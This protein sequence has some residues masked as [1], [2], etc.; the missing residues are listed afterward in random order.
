VT[1]TLRAL[2]ATGQTR[3]QDTR[4]GGR[5]R[6]PTW[7]LAGVA[8]VLFA[9]ATFLPLLASLMQ[10]AVDSGEAEVRAVADSRAAV[11]VATDQVQVLLQDI[12]VVAASV[13]GDPNFWD[14]DDAARDAILARLAA[15]RPTFNAVSFFTE[16][17]RQHGSSS[18]SPGEPRA[19][20]TGRAYAREAVAT[21]QT[22]FA[23]EALLS[24][25]TKVPVL[26][27]AVPVRDEGRPGATGREGLIVVALRLERLPAVWADLALP[28]GSAMA[29][30]DAR[31]GRV[32]AG[33][34]PAAG[35]TNELLARGDL[36]RVGRGEREFRTAAPDLDPRG[37][38]RLRAWSVVVDTPWAVVVD[39]PDAAVLAP[40]A[41][42]ARFRAVFAL[43]LAGAVLVPLLFLWRRLAEGL[44]RLAA[45]T[46]R[47]AAGDWAHRAG[48]RGGD[49]LGALGEACDRMAAQLEVAG[50]KLAAAEREREVR[51]RELEAELARAAQLQADLLPHGAPA[52]PGLDV[53]ARCLPARRVGGDFFDWHEPAPGVL[54]LTLGDVMGKGLPA[55]LLM[56]TVRAA[57]DAVEG[58]RSPAQ[59]LDAVAAATA[60][61]LERA[62]AFVTMF[63]ARAEAASRRVAYA[64]AGHGHAFVRRAGGAVEALPARGLP[65]G[66]LPGQHYPAGVLDLAPG[67]ALVVYSDGLIDARPDLALDPAALA[68]GL[69][70]AGSAAE[71]VDRLTGL[72]DLSQ[73]LPDDLTVIVLRRRAPR[74]A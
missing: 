69:D 26:P 25:N 53:A 42:A 45:A 2:R 15:P 10:S 56:A 8:L 17:L 29:L 51:R 4:P 58:G 38:P 54:T 22:A 21:G 70:G 12:R 37:T 35:R 36:E 61:V 73:D 18:Y 9:A 63:H 31:E 47:W 34:G 74:T 1:L 57:L 66:V 64:D 3:R 33:S 39:L 23:A 13:R 11:A 30:V 50:Q 27:V 28:A 60:P 62:G 5:P 44:G 55:A 46:E 52:V 19:E 72:A 40:I 24:L 49:E 41:A 67:D 71:I 43:A 59:T 32:L 16:D 14:G 65:L 7:S 48:V 20:V 68:A 6:R